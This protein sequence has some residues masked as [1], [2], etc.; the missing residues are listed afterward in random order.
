MSSIFLIIYGKT[1]RNKGKLTQFVIAGL[2]KTLQVTED[3]FPSLL[4]FTPSHLLCVLYNSRTTSWL[5]DSVPA[6]IFSY[7]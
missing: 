4:Y 3:R 7:V 1:S 6:N 2:Q 5:N